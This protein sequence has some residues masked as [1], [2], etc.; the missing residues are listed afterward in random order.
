MSCRRC[1]PYLIPD[2]RESSFPRIR[3]L[4]AEGV[5]SVV[6]VPMVRDGR[7]FGVLNVDG[8][9]PHAFTVAH[10]GFLESLSR[11]L[12]LAV[13]KAKLLGEL[14]EQLAERTRVEEELRQA[15]KVAEAASRAKSEFLA[16]MSH[17]IRTPM[18][19]VIGMTS[20][21][22]D[23]ALTPEQREYADMVRRR[24]RPC[25]P[26]STT[27]WTSRRSRR[28]GSSSRPSTS[29]CRWSS[30]RRWSCWPRARK[31]KGWSW[32]CV[33]Q[34]DVPRIVTGDP[35]RLRQILLNLVGNAVKFTHEGERVGPR[36]PSRRRAP[37]DAAIRG[38]PTRASA[39]RP[40]G[41]A[42]LFEP[43]PRRT[44]RPR[45]STA[46]PAWASPSASD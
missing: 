33:I 27:S 28:A 36:E 38:A 13:D 17:E 21:L 11:H 6:S 30:M 2:T 1:S 43:L 35:G 15:T 44:P 18:N 34:P 23:T 45:A 32:R 26:S 25:S 16:N 14:Q 5:L 20:L 12:G 10:I 19:G 46:A 31:P 37:D 40:H 8:S 3:E 7:C 42:R 29:T 4:E 39:S 41:R 24:A 22:L 9:R